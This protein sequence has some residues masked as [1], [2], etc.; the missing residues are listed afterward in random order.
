MF[1]PQTPKDDRRTISRQV[2]HAALHATRAA[3]LTFYTAWPV[4]D[5]AL[6]QEILDIVQQA[7]R[8]SPMRRRN[9]SG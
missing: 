8:K 2:L 3:A 6:T 7:S 1:I 9:L 5:Q 4:A